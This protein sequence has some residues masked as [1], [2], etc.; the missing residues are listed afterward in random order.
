M[1]ESG[2][3]PL[4]GCLK[5]PASD[6]LRV[7]IFPSKLRLVKSVCVVAWI[8]FF[9]VIKSWLLITSSVCIEA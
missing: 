6:L 7:V 1:L 9:A 3:K 8:I 2:D 5:K 4:T